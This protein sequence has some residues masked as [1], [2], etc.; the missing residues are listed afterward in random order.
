MSG[1]GQLPEGA[2][3]TVD[4]APIIYI[5]ENHPRYAD[6]FAPLFA[7]IEQG[8]LRAVIASITLAEVLCGPLRHGNEIL[9][10]RYH[11][12][13]TTS[14]NWH[15]QP[16]TT[17]IAAMAA[18]IRARYGFRLPDATQVAT[19]IKTGSTAL[20]THDRDFRELKEITVIDSL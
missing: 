13:L 2:V 19:A 16:L 5:L 20:V 14:P 10:D 1:I 18:R 8:S 9:A 4:T 11:Q 12:V 17:D 6:R 7:R 15:V 3:V